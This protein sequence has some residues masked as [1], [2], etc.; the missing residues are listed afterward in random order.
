M[1]HQK[2]HKQGPDN[3][4]WRQTYKAPS[5][6]LKLECNRVISTPFMKFYMLTC[7][8]DPGQVYTCDATTGLPRKQSPDGQAQLD[9]GGKGV[10]NLRA[11][12]TAKIWTLIFLAVRRRYHCTSASNWI[13]RP[14]S[15]VILNVSLMCAHL[16]TYLPNF[17]TAIQDHTNVEHVIMSQLRLRMIRP[18]PDQP[19]RFRRSC[20][21]CWLKMFQDSEFDDILPGMQCCTN[22]NFIH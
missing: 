17:T 21:K 1:A 4:K 9:V 5:L 20:T 10:N 6:H 13:I 22:S 19:D 3:T 12:R 2:L 18:W 15:L 11:K 16:G 7:A 14:G 8:T